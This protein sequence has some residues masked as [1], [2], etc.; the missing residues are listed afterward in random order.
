MYVY[1]VYERDDSIIVV[2]HKNKFTPQE[3]ADVYGKGPSSSE[4]FAR[5]FTPLYGVILDPNGG[6]GGYIQ[7]GDFNEWSEEIVFNYNYED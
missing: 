1:I 5:G 2:G 7:S 6:G 3:F 4:L